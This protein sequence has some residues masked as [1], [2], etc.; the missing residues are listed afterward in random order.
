[1]KK[2]WIVIGVIVTL[3]IVG[4]VGFYFWGTSAKSNQS[5]IV[6]FIIEPGTSKTTIA[7]NLENAGLIRS[8]YA[9]DM[10]LFFSKSNIQ[11]GEYELSPSMS[12]LDMLKKFES[13]DIK[14]HSVTVTLLEGKRL[15]DYAETL[16]NSF[17]F[18][19][20]EFMD[21]VDNKE[22]VESLVGNEDYWFL[23]EDILNSNIYH[24]LEGYLYPDTYE[25]LESMTPEEIVKSILNSTSKKLESYK[26]QLTNGNRKIHEYFTMASIVEKEANTLEERKTVSQV[27]YSRLNANWS[28]GSD[29]TAY[30]GVG[31]ILGDD[32]SISDLNDVNPY[33]TRLTDGQMN[34]KLPIGPIANPS[35]TSIEAAL[36][37]SETNYMFFVANVCTGEVFFQETSQEF[38]NKVYELQSVCDKN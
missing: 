37:P 2:V 26:E 35:I 17:G 31:K 20:K 19:K 24:P 33:N 15:E 4:V 5:N 36:D 7:K 32:I 23:T 21:A 16:A 30:Y 13:G 9:L 1:M 11:A 8:Q 28:L 34:G 27:F 25:F 38:Y 18:T 22:F 10:Y 29:V 14:I 3:L 12:P 6:T